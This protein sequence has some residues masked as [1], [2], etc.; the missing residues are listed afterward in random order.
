MISAKS[1]LAE[2]V[3]DFTISHIEI[4]R[5][6]NGGYPTMGSLFWAG[7]AGAE[8][9]G[10]MNGKTAVASNGEITGITSAILSTSNA[11]IE[12]LKQQ[13]TLLQGIL[14]KEFGISQD[15]LFKSVRTS[16]REYT[17][18]TGNYAF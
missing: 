17:N 4:P 10:S 6:A 16:A 11:E 9:V 7:E 3:I 8:I 2:K 12:V 13:N 15:D 1:V 18:R 14:E 5:F